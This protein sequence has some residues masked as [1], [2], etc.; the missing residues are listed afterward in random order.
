MYNK[1]Q[2]WKMTNVRKYNEKTTAVFSEPT[3][4]TV[5]KFLQRHMH[6]LNMQMISIYLHTSNILYEELIG[7]SEFENCRK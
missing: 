5:D 1:K 4:L 3:I 7:G 2:H 6:I